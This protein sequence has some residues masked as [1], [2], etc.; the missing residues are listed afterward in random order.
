MRLFGAA[1][2]V[3]RV[4]WMAMPFSLAFKAFTPPVIKRAACATITITPA[5]LASIDVG[6]AL[7]ADIDVDPAL[8]AS[9]RVGC[10]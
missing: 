9:L 1:G 2:Q 3:D 6:P 8:R 5:L 7:R 10:C 4:N